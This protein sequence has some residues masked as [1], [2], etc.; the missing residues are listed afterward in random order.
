MW[1]VKEIWCFSIKCRPFSAKYRHP[2]SIIMSVFA[3]YFCSLYLMDL[4]LFVMHSLQQ[5]STV[6]GAFD[7]GFF[8]FRLHF[9]RQVLHQLFHYDQHSSFQ[10]FHFF[11]KDTYIFSDNMSQKREYI[12]IITISALVKKILGGQVNYLYIVIYI[13]IYKHGFKI[14]AKKSHS[15]TCWQSFENILFLLMVST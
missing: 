2:N 8:S 11:F 10:F 7:W 4:N 15:F 5:G 9:N 6:D 13:Y 14:T 1:K 12:F 3:G